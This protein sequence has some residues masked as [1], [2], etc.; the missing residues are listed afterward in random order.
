MTG[1]FPFGI[2]G[3]HTSSFAENR[4]NRLINERCTHTEVLEAEQI[5]YFL[6]ILPIQQLPLLGRSLPLPCS[7]G[8]S[9]VVRQPDPEWPS[10][11]PS[12]NLEVGNFGRSALGFILLRIPICIH[13]HPLQRQTLLT[14]HGRLPIFSQAI[15]PQT[16]NLIRA[17]GGGHPHKRQCSVEGQGISCPR[18]QISLGHRCALLLPYCPLVQEQRSPRKRSASS[19]VHCSGVRI[20]GKCVKSQR[21]TASRRD[22]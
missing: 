11:L 15:E 18:R 12:G 6:A 19:S 9:S 3:A 4:D 1:N 13:G 7:D 20:A 16:R 2:L 17:A 5:V 21:P 10:T 14:Q 22:M 8:V